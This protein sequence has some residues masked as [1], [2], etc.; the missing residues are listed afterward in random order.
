MR[1]AGRFR[2]T[3]YTLMEIA[4][5]P[6]LPG[7]PPAVAPV[8]FETLTLQNLRCFGEAV[9]LRFTDPNDKIAQW[10]IILGDNGVGKTTILQAIA[11]LAP[12]VSASNEGDEAKKKEKEEKLLKAC[13]SLQD[14]AFEPFLSRCANS[15]ARVKGDH[16]GGAFPGY[17]A[18]PWLKVVSAIRHG[19]LIDGD[20]SGHVVR[21]HEWA[22][23]GSLNENGGWKMVWSVRKEAF[24]G[25]L[26]VYGYGASR[27]MAV[28]GRK[29]FGT[30]NR[31]ATETMFD[32]ESQIGNAEEWLLDL[33]QLAQMPHPGQKLAER[34][35]AEVLEILPHVLPDVDQIKFEVDTVG[36]ARVRPKFHT[37]FG[38]LPI[39]ALSYGYQTMV[40][41]LVDLTRRMLER[42]PDAADPLK[43]PAIVLVDEIDLHLHPR[44]QRE[45]M[46]Y[47]SERFP[48]TQFIV[49]A[50]SPLIIQNQRAANV[51]LLERLPSVKNQPMRVAVR[52]DLDEV[53]RWRV[54]QIL[55]SDLF[56]LPT[57]ESQHAEKLETERDNLLAKSKLTPVDRK[58]LAEID[59]ALES[60]P[61][62]SSQAAVKAE[63]LFRQAAQLLAVKPA[64][65]KPVKAK[66]VAVR[67]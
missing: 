67:K 54:D 36:A 46:D 62:F 6:A 51:I 61:A 35:L 5:K 10:T 24:I 31:E 21:N 2:R 63:E 28:A 29:A 13:V 52:Q 42:Y 65:K 39:E 15:G 55:T 8:Y 23:A 20:S 22:F 17:A 49:T 18:W 34:R 43:M 53:K 1:L 37:S 11:G 64:V 25:G 7:Q 12:M 66:R 48:N 47:L 4:Q 26:V 14:S 57:V 50:H 45:V 44:W 56:G 16:A 9:T 19:E 58:R 27:R 40:S 33:H 41:W 30:G 60:L 38:W 32:N 3:H 59:A